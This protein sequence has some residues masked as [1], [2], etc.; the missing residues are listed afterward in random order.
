MRVRQQGLDSSRAAGTPGRRRKLAKPARPHRCFCAGRHLAYDS[1]RQVHAGDIPKALSP[2]IHGQQRVAAAQDQNPVTRLQVWQ[3]QVPEVCEGLEPLVVVFLQDPNANSNVEQHSMR[4]AALT[5]LSSSG[6]AITADARTPSA[7]PIH[8]LYIAGAVQEVSQQHR[9]S[10]QSSLWH[11]SS[12]A[13]RRET[14]RSNMGRV[15][16][17]LKALIPVCR[18]QVLAV[19]LRQEGLVTLCHGIPAAHCTVQRLQS[20]LMLLAR[21]LMCLGLEEL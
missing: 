5:V 6:C 18:I 15:L 13:P 10:K 9:Q 20:Q 8:C 16:D 11:D 2:Q 4:V 12:V 21:I 1:W 17:L 3:Q 19:V 7:Y 14:L